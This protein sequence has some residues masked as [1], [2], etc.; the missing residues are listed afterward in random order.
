M[1]APGAGAGAAG[2]TDDKGCEERGGLLNV[3]ISGAGAV[4]LEQFDQMELVLFANAFQFQDFP[5]IGIGFV[6]NVN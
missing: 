2:T 4:S 6:G 1:Y 3:C 5:E